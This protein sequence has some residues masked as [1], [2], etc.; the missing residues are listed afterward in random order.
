M[1]RA[2]SSERQGPS[3]HTRQGEPLLTHLY[4]QFR[5]TQPSKVGRQLRR[6]ALSQRGPDGSLQTLG[7]LG[8][9]AVRP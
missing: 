1:S 5:D 8:Q 9:L 6:Q 3:R 2:G 7:A 4:A